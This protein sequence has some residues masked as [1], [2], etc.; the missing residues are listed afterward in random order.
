[1]AAVTRDSV[2]VVLPAYNRWDLTCSCLCDLAG[3]TMPARV[4]VVENGSEDQTR[5]ALRRDW[6]DVSVLEM[7]HN[8]RFTEAVNRGVAAGTGE[9]VVLLNN[10][11]RLRPDFLERLIG[12]LRQDPSVGS[13]ASLMLV[14]GEQV[15]DSFGVTADSTLAGFARLHG[16]PLSAV[17][18]QMPVLAGAEGTAGAYRRSAWEQ[19]GGLDET[20][21]AYM[22]IL[23]LALRLRV[24]GWSAVGAADAVGVHLGSS[25][26]GHR[27]AQQRRLAGFSRGYLLRRYGVLRGTEAPRTLLTEATVILGDALLSRDLHALRGRLAGWRAAG[28]QPRHSRPPRDA[29]DGSISLLGSWRLRFAAAVKTPQS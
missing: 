29:I 11:V 16:L 15:I 13:V 8:H 1:M 2:D 9:H 24:A 27:S 23:D 10:D 4:I 7:D 19:V 3:Q 22:E 26:F 12:P 17:H 28:G 6:P 21:S 5:E 18:G 14:P 25:T 20:I